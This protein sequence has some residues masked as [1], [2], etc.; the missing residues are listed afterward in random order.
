[1]SCVPVDLVWRG[2]ERRGANI[3]CPETDVKVGLGAKD[4]VRQELKLK[5]VLRHHDILK[6]F[7]KASQREELIQESL[8]TS[9]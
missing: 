3:G 6:L 9:W 8:V 5:I 4:T 1:M 2:V 7:D